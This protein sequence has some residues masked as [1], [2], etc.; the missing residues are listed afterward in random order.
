MR[1]VLAVATFAAF[2]LLFVIVNR[3]AYQ[4]YFHGDEL[5]NI[6]WTR[7]LSALDWIHGFLSPR[8]YAQNFRPV[9]HLYFSLMARAADLDFR[10]YVLS[11]HALH[12]LNVVLLWRLLRRPLELS[13]W[14]AGSGVLL[15]AFHMGV[16]DALWKPMYVFDLLCAA[17]SLA[18]LSAY[19]GRGRARWALSFACFWLALK[20]KE[21]AVMLPAALLLWEF[22]WGRKD[23]KRPAPF[24][25][26]SLAFGIQALLADVARQSAYSF[27]F[28]PAELCKSL[29]FYSSKIF[30]LPHA[31]VALLIVPWLLRDRRAWF[32]L[33]FFALLLTPM[34]LLSERLF[35]A[36]LYLPLAGLAITAAVAA[37]RVP[38]A[39]VAAFF[40]LW[41]PWNHASLRAQRR[42]ALSLAD[43]S[44]RYVLRLGEIVRSHP[45]I[46]A[47]VY[48][49]IPASLQ[50]WGLEAAIGYFAGH[51]DFRLHSAEE[52]G[53]GKALEE[54][55]GVALLSWDPV[56][57]EL[58]VFTRAPRQPEA[59]YIT[60]GRLAPAWQFGEGWYASGGHFRW[61]RPYATARLYRPPGAT[62]FELVVNMGPPPVGDAVSAS[63][64]LNGRLVGSK[65]LP[66]GSGWH[67]VRWPLPAGPAGPV[68]VEIRVEPPF[69]A[70]P[71]RPLGLAVSAFGFLPRESL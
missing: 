11:I 71:A 54:G 45:A 23:W 55:A 64:F 29:E 37:S 47:F 60:V 51:G 53:L 44:R 21:L 28:S 34:L 12:L 46:R 65:A 3:G 61:C 7:Y 56:R 14:A 39:A 66:R 20:S 35:G 5:N 31:G 57:R 63:V 62:Q 8:Y 50:S 58:A 25:I 22:L 48:D 49:G 15:F 26:V 67:T 70:D 18:C 36:Y 33:A 9:G 17:F 1:K 68:Q 52:R 19:T 6:Y 69:V 32:G 38:R 40:L 59:S 42:E 2:A 24:L 41:L 27:H 16:F 4:G 43:E 30:L 10:W 13:A